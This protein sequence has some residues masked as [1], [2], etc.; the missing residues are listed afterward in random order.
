MSVTNSSASNISFQ[1]WRSLLTL[2]TAHCLLLLAA[3][4]CSPLTLIT[5]KTYC[6]VYSAYRPSVRTPVID[7]V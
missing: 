3:S 7:R 4:C 1:V 2:L 5:H 6:T